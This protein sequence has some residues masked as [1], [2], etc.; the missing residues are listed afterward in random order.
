MNDLIGKTILARKNTV[1]VARFRVHSVEFHDRNGACT[2]IML[3]ENLGDHS[4]GL[5]DLAA[6]ITQGFHLIIEYEEQTK[7]YD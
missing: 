3:L 4:I 1:I 5:Y 2:Y 7:L 6:V